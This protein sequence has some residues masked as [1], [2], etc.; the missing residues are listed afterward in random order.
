MF[1]M[2]HNKNKLWKR[3]IFQFRHHTRDRS[4]RI[5][6]SLESVASNFDDYELAMSY[7]AE[8]CTKYSRFI[9]NHPK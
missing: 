1:C 5:D 8:I 9:R 2:L 3:L 7:L 4:K 6:A